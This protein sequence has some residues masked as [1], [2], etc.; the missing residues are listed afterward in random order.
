MLVSSRPASRILA[1][2][3][4]KRMKTTERTRNKLSKAAAV[5]VLIAG[6]FFAVLLQLGIHTEFLVRGCCER[7]VAHEEVSGA[8]TPSSDLKVRQ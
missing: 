3:E 5:A 8:L 7:R 2:A 6:F 1:D 4:L